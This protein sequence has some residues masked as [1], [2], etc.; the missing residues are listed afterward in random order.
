MA[1][2]KSPQS[3]ESY[4][5]TCLSKSSYIKRTFRNLQRRDEARVM[6]AQANAKSSQWT[7]IAG[8]T[9]FNALRNR[10][11]DVIPWDYS[12][13]RLSLGTFEDGND[14]FNG[15]YICLPGQYS[16]QF[17]ATQVEFTTRKE[18]I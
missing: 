7:S 6:D 18:K 5:A 17:I 13:T 3:F 10:Y 9:E 2:F 1:T 14:Y 4:K 16:K 11:T 8:N 12:R 15:S